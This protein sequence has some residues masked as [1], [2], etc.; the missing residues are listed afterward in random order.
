[1]APLFFLYQASRISGNLSVDMSVEFLPTTYLRVPGSIKPGVAT[2]GLG[3][4]PG[5]LRFG[6]TGG[7]TLDPEP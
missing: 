3:V 1:M 4:A 2:E 5:L 7:T 6:G